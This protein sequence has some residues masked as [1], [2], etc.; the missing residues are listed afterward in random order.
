MGKKHSEEFERIKRAGENGYEYAFTEYYKESFD[1]IFDWERDEFEDLIW[2]KY[3]EGII[4]F[5]NLLPYL[6]K[7]DGISKLQEDLASPGTPSGWKTIIISVL[8]SSAK[9]N[10]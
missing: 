1:K 5:A 9:D 3:N 2:K 4:K 7:Y 6:K 10:T 8:N